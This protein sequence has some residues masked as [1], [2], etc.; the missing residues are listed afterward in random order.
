MIL[1]RCPAC[2]TVHRA[3]SQYAGGM[4]PCQ[5][6]R[7]QVPIPQ[8]SDPE[9]ALI[10]KAGESE[11][12]IPMALEEIRL[13][14]VSGELS[15]TDLVWDGSTW[16]PLAEV[17]G[18]V[19]E[20]DGLRLKQRVEEESEAA[21][22][23]EE[24]A[25]SLDDLTPIQ[26][27]DLDASTTGDRSRK[28]KRRRRDRR[29]ARKAAK[30]A[31]AASAK[32]VEGAEAGEARRAGKKRG[33]KG[34]GYYAAQI[35]MAL[36]AV[37]LG[38]KYGFG[39]L[40]SNFR[41]LPSYVLIHN[42]EGATYDARLGWRAR[43]GLGGH[44]TAVFGNTMAHL[45]LYVGLPETRTLSVVPTESGSGESFSVRVP[46]R[47][48]GI[49]LVNCRGKGTYGL[50]T[51]QAV[52]D[53]KLD[54]P[55]LKKLGAEIAANRSPD[56]A[57]RVSRQIRDLVD[58]AFMGTKNDEV[59][60]SSQYRFADSLLVTIREKLARNP[61]ADGGES[62]AP[63]RD[64]PVLHFPASARVSF[65]NGAAVQGVAENAPVER[66]VSLPVSA[67]NLN[68]NRIVKAKS[69][70]LT[71]RVDPT[72][73]RLRIE[74]ANASVNVSNQDFT[75]VWVYQAS[76][77][78]EGPGRNRWSWHWEFK[79][80]AKVRNRTLNCTLKVNQKGAE[81]KSVK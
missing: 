15:E 40:I 3:E 2:G 59:F 56:T 81:T 69:P 46:I 27:V 70:R 73:I 62:S 23:E 28:K 31:A 76:C 42:H 65:A 79:G 71:I 25:E 38:Y 80:S 36:L 45:E 75:G 57:I 43:L 74:L 68:Q 29:A 64:V 7:E 66:E 53:K 19:S 30:A 37:V 58:E 63:A 47:P 9:C 67:F 50:Y 34:R 52:E 5:N 49:S 60:R 72:V 61:R 33:P 14:M 17:I 78:L 11:D 10:Y 51:M 1:F 54:T 39:P 24:L 16:R 18:G 13:N 77:P 35:V 41:G 12:G 22:A 21:A 4:I 48:A 26:K 55:E 6:C 8:E 44:R 20:G 32:G